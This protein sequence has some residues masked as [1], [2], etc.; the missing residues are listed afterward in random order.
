[1]LLITDFLKSKGFTYCTASPTKYDLENYYSVVIRTGRYD[2][3]FTPLLAICFEK[4]LSL[5]TSLII[6]GVPKKSIYHYDF[7]K[8]TFFKNDSRASRIKVYGLDLSRREL[9]NE[10]DR[11]FSKKNEE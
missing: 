4:R 9:I 10:V 1:M 3:P 7:Y 2:L 6:E 11:F 8:A 5:A